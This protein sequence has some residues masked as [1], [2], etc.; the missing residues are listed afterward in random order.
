M[1]ESINKIDNRFKQL[2]KNTGV[3]FAEYFKSFEFGEN[4][5]N[6]CYVFDDYIRETHDDI[7]IQGFYSKLRKLAAIYGMKYETNGKG[8]AKEFKILKK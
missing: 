3:D 8:K 5:H 6:G 7:G 1:V 4:W 2:V